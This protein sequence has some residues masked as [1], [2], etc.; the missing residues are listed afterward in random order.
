M[1]TIVPRRQEQWLE[2]GLQWD[3]LCF[4]AFGHPWG[5]GLSTRWGEEGGRQTDGPGW[6]GG[7]EGPGADS[8]SWACLSSCFRAWPASSDSASPQTRLSKQSSSHRKRPA[9]RSD[10]ALRPRAF[11]LLNQPPL[12][13]ICLPFQARISRLGFSPHSVHSSAYTTETK[14]AKD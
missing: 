12:N 3:P 10:E 13:R 8:L 9:P 5:S 6:E 4:W 11:C 1:V 14:G 2:L 7:V